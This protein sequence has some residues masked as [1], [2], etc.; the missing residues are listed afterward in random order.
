M[1]TTSS[2][3]APPARTVSPCVEIHAARRRG[4]QC[5]RSAPAQP[6]SAR[7]LLQVTAVR[8][9]YV[10]L[11]RTVC[12]LCRQA[13]SNLGLHV[14]VF[15]FAYA[16]IAERDEVLLAGVHQKPEGIG[17]AGHELVKQGV[18]VDIAQM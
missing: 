4:S 2:D 11:L 1:A 10:F 9:S 6:E 13:A 14:R 3:S 16:R 5:P 15:P 18:C 7:S 8:L 12:E 17:L